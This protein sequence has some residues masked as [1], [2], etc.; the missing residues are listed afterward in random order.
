MS[1]T[2]DYLELRKKRKKESSALERRNNEIN[3]TAINYGQEGDDIAPVKGGEKTSVFKSGG[4]SDGVDG[5]GDF[6]VD[7][8]Q[9]VYGTA[10]DIGGGLVRG[11]GGLAEGLVDLI[12]YGTAEVVESLGGNEQGVK[13]I[14]KAAQKD[15]VREWTQ[16]AVDFV[17]QYSV[18]GDKADMVSEGLGQVGGIILTGGLGGAAG[19][20][21]LGTSVLTTAVTGLSGAGSGMGE[22]YQ[23]GATDEE[24]W[25]YGLT[26]GAIEAGTE[27]LFG[28]L[29]KASKAI[30]IG[31]SAIPL[32]DILAKAATK[33]ITSQIGKNL[34]EYG[35]KATAEGVEEVIAGYLTAHAKKGTY[36]PE[37][38]FS[39]I[40]EDERLLE[41]FLVGT[42]TSAIAQSGSLVQVSTEGR[43]FVTGYTQNEQSV[44]NKE[45]ENRI[46]EREKNGNKL[47]K[48][49][50]GKIEERVQSDLEKG[51]I[52]TDT[53]EEVLGGDSYKAYKE[54][55]KSEEILK[56][57]YEELRQMKKGEMNDIQQDRLAELKAMNLEENSKSS[58]LKTQ[59]DSEISKLIKGSR[60]AESYNEVAR[61]SQKFE[62][63]LNQYQDD[64]S[65]KTIK[66]IMDSGIANNTNLTHEFA[67][68]LAKMSADQKTVFDFTDNEKLKASIFGIDGKN[69]NGYITKDGITINLNSP[70]ALQT[71]VG[72]E[73]SHVLEG[74]DLY[75]SLQSELKSYLGDA[76]YSKRLAAVKENYKDIYTGEDAETK[77]EQELTA[78]LV[79][80]LLFTDKNFVSRLYSGNRNLFQKIFDEVKYLCR[81]ATAGSKQAR[82][83]EKIKHTFEEVY[84][85]G[86][87]AQKNTATEDGVRYS[88][89]G[90]TID[91]TGI[92]KTNYPEDTPKSVKQNDLI[93]LVQNA[94]SNNPITLEIVEN[95]TIKKIEAKFNPELSERSDLSKIAF[96]NRKG[97]GSEKRM[98]LDLS[99][100]LYQIASDSR[101]VYSKDATPKPDNPAH[102]DVT[103]Y[104]YFLT[105]LVYQDNN[106]NYI[107]CHMN[108]DVK[109]NTDGNWFY[110]FAIEKGS[111]PQTLLAVVTEKSATLPDNSI[112]NP[113]E[114]VNGKLSLS[115]KNEDIA[116]VK[117]GI[118]GKDIALETASNQDLAPIR[119]DIPKTAKNSSDDDIAP[120]RDDI[121]LV[122][123]S[124][125]EDIAPVREDVAQRNEAGN[126]NAVSR[127]LNSYPVEKQKVIRS[128]LRAVDK[129]IKAFVERV[130]NGDLRFERKKISN[131]SQRAADDIKKLLG[132]DAAGYTNNINTS[133]VQH[134]IVRHGANGKQDTTM[135]VDDDIARVGWVLENY[136]SVELLTENG[137]QVYSSSFMDKNNNPAPQVRFIKKI[138]GT[139]YVVEAAF[140]NDYKKLWVQSAYLQKNEDVTQA[141]ADGNTTI[142]GANA[143]S[144]L[145]SPSSNNSISDIAP[146]VNS[147][148]ND[149]A[150][151]AE[152]L[153]KNSQNKRQRKWVETSTESDVVNREILPDELEQSEITYVPISN[154]ETMA[155]ANSKLGSMGY[156]TAVEYV[157]N[158][159]YSKKISLE[160]IALGEKL[161]QE[162]VKIGDTKT[163]GEL[164]QNIAIIG[165]ELGQKVQ[166]LSI[167]KRMTPEGQLKMLKKIID[168]GKS[169]GDKIFDGVEIT[170]E[171][172]DKILGVYD[173]DGSYDQGELNR[174]V[175]D[176]KLKIA[177]QMEV[178]FGERINAWRYLSMLGNPKTHIRNM[179]SNI[180]M[181][182]TMAVKDAV[183]RTI[184]TV[185]P[186]E[187]RTKTWKRSTSDVK[188]FAKRTAVEMKQEI[189]G[190][191]KYSDSSDIKSKRGIFKNE[192]LQK[193]Y[194]FN[195]DMLSKEDWWFSKSAFESSLKEFL[196]ANGIETRRDISSNPEIVE[197]GKRYALE[198][199]EIATFRQYSWLASKIGGIEQKNAAMQIGVGSVIPFKKTP[200]NIAKV[201]LSY[202]PLGF[203][204]TLTYDISQVKKGNME[205]STLV[206]HL[207]Q[208]IVGSG[209]ALL[210]YM[211]AKAGF[212]NGGGE[213]DK[214]GKYDY[215]LGEQSYSINIGGSS[216][217]LSWISP[218][219]MP[220]FVGANAY[221][222]LV[223][224]KEWNADVVLETLA[225]TLDPLSEM[226]F[227]SSLDDVLSSYDSGAE[228]F[229]GIGV[230]GLQ[231]YIT[232]FVPTALSQMAAVT[233]DAKRTTK[234]AA[235]SDS[236]IIDEVV[237]QLKYKIPGLRQTLEPTI[238]I[239]GDEI[240][241]DGSISERAF[242]NIIA[243]W[244]EKTDISTEV[245]LE[246]KELYSEVGESEIL[247]SIPSNSVT[248]KDQKYEMSAREY[249]D[250]KK[251][252]GQT[253]NSMLHRLFQTET[254][255]KA[256]AKDKAKMVTDVYEYARDNA[257]R[258]YLLK[259]GVEYT[260][261]SED[262]VEYYKENPIVGAIESDMA[263]DEYSFFVE[264]P[265][266]YLVSR[267]SGGFEAYTEHSKTLNKI[268]ADKYT[269]GKTVSGSR[270]KKVIEY[271]NSL[272]ADYGE[273]II[274]FKS[275]YTGDD[276]YNYEIVEYLN[277]RD[278]ISYTEIK[279][280]L[281]ELGFTV[282]SDGRVR[283]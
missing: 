238:D 160:D 209:L 27:L 15:Y 216:Y 226:S 255:Q 179:V 262:G 149:I 237:N 236:K 19:L 245:D 168:R 54:A 84:K 228:K 14:R 252:Y 178:T 280:I 70:K 275:Q 16:E 120:I 90:R 40:L 109:Q 227:L 171:M 182:G 243:P 213:D 68:M 34:V 244:Y 272:N 97:N 28:G 49:E 141:S 69:I 155:R 2:S 73:I 162:A 266:K 239:W 138:D 43:D 271:I 127:P 71:I 241:Q 159:I 190:E 8:G 37:K 104:H 46:A 56:K 110:S 191:S 51:Y 131:V 276:T 270:K 184:E 199:A 210:G 6:F 200:I 126:T 277:S 137:E 229:A 7:L 206:D 269:N 125:N 187:N 59:L 170:Q 261:A 144:A 9:T 157:K 145:V 249:T 175:E 246:L 240:K 197:K 133:G 119:T 248:F 113:D 87:K 193:V 50:I 31:K 195:N 158:Q 189:T 83:L 279:T 21:T 30:G 172:T 99:S 108:I 18:L 66:N 234:V 102:D 173:E 64:Y 107:P 22:A 230:S 80:D 41:S 194:G 201:G 242:D 36:M 233:D 169:K 100:D 163:A 152:N 164:I 11:F 143:Q 214:E 165:T 26:K 282:L 63:D 260:N 23:G 94:W 13:G 224:D 112:F 278:D 134:I 81:V 35:I 39:E 154:R 3:G 74:A 166:A 57:E 219:A 153:T 32:D 220:L 75:S 93:S 250:Y 12:L 114:N 118:Y 42:L 217:S 259:E 161:I 38:D 186:I 122:Q 129:Q 211:L 265:E 4:F 254:Y 130:K 188:E 123:N 47:T 176:V 204:K 181:A 92:Y 24:A 223:E 202:S 156:D 79:G 91:G 61:R 198:R 212:L 103:K 281:E 174:A 167:I 82:Q 105:N 196:T 5:V 76:E 77:F 116:P 218:A 274:L 203:V 55:L 177:E 121:K 25:K 208:N 151:I 231:N 147:T 215:Q 232:Q 251:T 283:W 273:K 106:N 221:E 185:L 225:Q 235:D 180:A 53:I 135:S 136:D 264:Y 89:V 101:Y 60:L 253:A 268:E 48:N 192:I 65:K 58:Q 111:A 207:S 140:E 29:G 247:P 267:V 150:P 78:D 222:Q 128:Y 44:I 146:V 20:G 86:A 85:E 148:D 205:A 142:H 256:S 98:T 62:A 88:L 115:Y 183:A 124:N 17:D 132:I 67:D 45:V 52:S 263:V 257:K 258:E 33:K 10:A 1:F 72:H 95:G 139:Y 117:D 96:G